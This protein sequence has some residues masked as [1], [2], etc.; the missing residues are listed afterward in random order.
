MTRFFRAA[1]TTRR[2]GKLAAALVSMMF[3]T[4]AL[5]A[6]GGYLFVTFKG[7]R[8][9]MSEQ[10]YFVV[11]EDGRRW[12]ALNKAEPTLVSAIGERGVRDPFLVRG[13]DG[14][15]FYLIATDLSIHLNH[16]WGRAVRGGSKSIVVW[17]STD[18]V[19][20]SEPR[21]VKVA[22][23]DA[24]CTW[25]PE[26]V[27]DEASGDYLVFWAS[28]NASD[29]FARHRIWGARTK[30][31]KTFA[32]PQVYIDKPTAVIDT[33]IVYDDGVYYRFTKDE[34]FKAITM[35]R[36]DKLDGPWTDVPN[37]SLAKLTGYEGPAAFKLKAE[38]GKPGTWCLLLDHYSKGEGYKPFVTSDLAGG[39]FKPGAD[40]VFPFPTRHGSVLPVTADE[41]A[42]LRQKYGVTPTT[43]PAK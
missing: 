42:R 19:N 41:L 17:E 5:A 18:L 32:P 21:L 34:K 8:T 3:P 33:D 13:H 15:T 23:D 29:N 27:Y 20:W 30:D 9:P 28:T 12:D 16:D 1:G 40:F 35:E 26:A 39:Q 43:K 2:M 24:G 11:S 14:K 37:F 7:E 4:F 38:A 36:A 6:D 22:P 25:A 10:V 31:F